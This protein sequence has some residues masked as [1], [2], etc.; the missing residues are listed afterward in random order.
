MKSTG[1]IESKQPYW[2][3]D[4][5]TE[6]KVSKDYE[7]RKSVK[8]IACQTGMSHSIIA[9]TLKS[10]NKV[11]EAVKGSVSLKAMR[12]TKIWERPIS[13]MEKLLMT[14][15]E[16]QTQKFITISTMKITEKTKSL[17]VMLKEKAEPDYDVEFTACS[18]WF[19]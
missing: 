16:D 6:L 2:V 13:D 15:I 3:I 18:G 5:E 11:M 17:F 19:K 12:L 9:T 14:W 10:K 8:I 1:N 4:Q 7:G